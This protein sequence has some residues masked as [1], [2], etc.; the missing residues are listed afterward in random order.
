MRHSPTNRFLFFHR[1]RRS[2]MENVWE[3]QH[4]RRHLLLVAK[5]WWHDLE[6]HRPQWR[7]RRIL[8][9]VHRDK[10]STNYR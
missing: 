2:G 3:L 1:H 10:F 4:E 9:R 5:E 7:Q 6:W 8:L